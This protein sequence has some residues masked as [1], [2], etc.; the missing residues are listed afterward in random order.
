MT[1]LEE[2]I[3]LAEQIPQLIKE[4]ITDEGESR[5]DPVKTKIALELVKFEIEKSI[6]CRAATNN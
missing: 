5:F 3:A 6:A 4:N 1:Q 2:I